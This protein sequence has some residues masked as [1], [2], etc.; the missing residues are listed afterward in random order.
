M[1]ELR[2]PL[3]F[4]ITKG[5]KQVFVSHE[6]VLKSPKLRQQVLDQVFAEILAWR[7]HYGD[8]FQLL[9]CPEG[10]HLVDEVD[11]TLRNRKQQTFIVR[12][13]ESKSGNR[14]SKGRRA[15]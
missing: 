10:M 9:D 3:L 1:S 14:P 2:I 4:E 8:T 11:N 6:Q 15:R 5:R 13:A 12:R 7:D